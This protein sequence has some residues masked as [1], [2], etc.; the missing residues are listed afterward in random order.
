MRV[1]NDWHSVVNKGNVLGRLPCQNGEYRLPILDA[2]HTSHVQDRGI[3]LANGIL[4]PVPSP[5][6]PLKIVRGR[7]QATPLQHT[8]AEQRLVRSGLA[9]G[10]YDLPSGSVYPHFIAK[11]V[12]TID[13][14]L[15]S[16]GTVSVG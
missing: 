3:T 7:D 11:G 12:I 9:S 6:F 8:V 14:L 16:T 4:D 13:L 10:V 5:L 2:I 15:A 1:K